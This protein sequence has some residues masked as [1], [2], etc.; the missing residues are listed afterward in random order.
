M[1][2][3][4][5]M[6]LIVMAGVVSAWVRC[7]LGAGE[8]TRGAVRFDEISAFGL[9]VVSRS[10]LC[11]GSDTTW[12]MIDGYCGQSIVRGDIIQVREITVVEFW[13]C[14][15]TDVESYRTYRIPIV[16]LS[17]TYHLLSCK[18]TQAIKQRKKQT[19][20][21]QT[22]EKHVQITNDAGYMMKL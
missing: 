14:S 22:A 15:D 20:K 18:P 10:M 13:T 1:S 7:G 3:P 5:F 2:A 9:C 8:T 21:L 16:Y 12:K 4:F 19:L 6:P 17:H 11:D